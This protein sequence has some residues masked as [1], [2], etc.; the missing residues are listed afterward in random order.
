[1]H[2]HGGRV[3]VAAASQ[4]GRVM[5]GASAYPQLDGTG[6][7]RMS[8]SVSSLRRCALAPAPAAAIM[9]GLAAP[10]NAQVIPSAN[11]EVAPPWNAQRIFEPSTLPSLTDADSREPLAPEDTPVKSRQQP[12]YEP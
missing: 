9:L 6:A 2:R 3:V 11:E 8:R 12:G 1:M 4:K 10:A 7:R 5:K